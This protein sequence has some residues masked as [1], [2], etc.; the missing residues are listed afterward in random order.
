M[1]LQGSIAISDRPNNGGPVI[2]DSAEHQRPSP[3]ADPPIVIHVT[4]AVGQQLGPGLPAGNWA[5]VP[6][7]PPGPFPP[8]RF[9][10]Y[11]YAV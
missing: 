6:G 3:A 11:R 1:A 8:G 2:D 9:A 4:V 10:G 5:P 7:L